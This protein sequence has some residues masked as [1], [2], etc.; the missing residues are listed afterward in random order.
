MINNSMNFREWMLLWEDSYTKEEI[1]AYFYVGCRFSEDFV[2]QNQAIDKIPEGAACTLVGMEGISSK[3]MFGMGAGIGLKMPGEKLLELN[4]ISQHMYKNPE[5][6]ASSGFRSPRRTKQGTNQGQSARYSRKEII[7][8]VI[9]TILSQIENN[10][11]DIVI[12]AR[13]K[14][15]HGS[16]NSYEIYDKLKELN[17]HCGPI[18][19]AKECKKKW[20]QRKKIKDGEIV[21]KNI[22]PEKDYIKDNIK[23][24]RSASDLASRLYILFKKLGV[25]QPERLLA[26]VK[27]PDL[28]SFVFNSL[29]NYDDNVPAQKIANDLK[30]HIYNISFFMR[31][32]NWSRKHKKPLNKESYE[33]FADINKIPAIIQFTRD[34]VKSTGWHEGEQEWILK[35][36]YAKGTMGV[37]CQYC[38]KF[39]TINNNN[40]DKET[41]ACPNCGNEVKIAGQIHRVGKLP[42]LHVPN[43]SSMYIQKNVNVPDWANKEIQEYEKGQGEPVE[44]FQKGE[45]ISPEI[46]KYKFI[47]NKYHLNKKFNIYFTTNSEQSQKF[48]L[49]DT[50]RQ[51]DP[52]KET[53][54]SKIEKLINNGIRKESSIEKRLYAKE[55]ISMPKIKSIIKNLENKGFLKKQDG[56]LYLSGSGLTEDEYDIYNFIKNSNSLEGMYANTLKNE[57]NMEPAEVEQALASLQDKGLI[58]KTGEYYNLSLSEEEKSKPETELENKI[59]NFISNNNVG[60][61]ESLKN[62]MANEKPEE[63]VSALKKLFMKGKIYKGVMTGYLRMAPDDNTPLSNDERIILDFMKE[64]HRADYRSIKH[65]VNIGQHNDISRALEGLIVRDLISR[66]SDGKFLINTKKFG[67]LKEPRPYSAME[68]TIL[69]V[70]KKHFVATHDAPRFIGSIIDESY[71]EIDPYLEVLMSKNLIVSLD[72][73]RLVPNVEGMTADEETLEERALLAILGTGNFG[74]EELGDK[75]TDRLDISIRSSSLNKL[76]AY[77]EKKGLIKKAFDPIKDYMIYALIDKELKIDFSKFIDAFLAILKEAGGPQNVSQIRDSYPD[78]ISGEA[79][80]YILN[81]MVKNNLIKADKD[82]NEDMVY[83]TPNQ[84]FLSMEDFYKIGVEFLEQNGPSSYQK[85]SNYVQAATGSSESNISVVFS[86]LVEEGKLKTEHINYVGDIWGMPDQE[87]PTS[88]SFKEKIY[89]VVA[90]KPGLTASEISDIVDI[91]SYG[92]GAFLAILRNEGKIEATNRLKDGTQVFHL[93]GIDLDT[94]SL[95]AIEKIVFDSLQNFKNNGTF[96]LIYQFIKN[97]YYY[98]NK[99]KAEKIIKKMVAD[100]KIFVKFG[101]FESNILT[102][103]FT[104]TPSNVSDEQAIVQDYGEK[105]KHLVDTYASPILTASGST[106]PATNAYTAV[107]MVGTSIDDVAKQYVLRHLVQAHVL[108]VQKGDVNSSSWKYCMVSL[109]DAVPTSAPLPSSQPGDIPDLIE[110]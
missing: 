106:V 40:K 63:V 97:K 47:I 12:N 30:S 83:T 68:Y 109:P 103:A 52:S 80:E 70:L 96:S 43:G 3:P 20:G 56:S 39:I 84:H 7:V 9:G 77:L 76:L 89:K 74:Q 101:N 110:A 33:T 19:K 93:P 90:E 67:D 94:E 72:N 87:L 61:I 108:V 57:L 29:G 104:L 98:L 105:A 85:L 60:N 75:M 32:I 95:P 81:D 6:L 37:N 17:P 64:W 71:Y 45:I 18:D 53:I 62:D 34:A 8:E 16:M 4:K 99:E 13:L 79:F 51:Y 41:V 55:K 5:Y 25:K 50:G 28:S 38:G 24:I 22:K 82:F 66:D 59:L 86:K 92:T 14:T 65:S 31:F 69:K 15:Q 42:M 44:G 73:G 58:V 23:N 100:K 48:A 78:Y 107:S 21:G 10:H 36:D 26:P 35:R 49:S 102:C 91:Q 88:G 1:P 46:N 11:E 27:H 2:K 54:L